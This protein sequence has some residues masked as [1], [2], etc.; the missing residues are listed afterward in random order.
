MK[1]LLLMIFVSGQALASDADCL[2]EILYAE[3]RG[4]AFE[5]VV[6]LGQASIKKADM[7]KSTLCALKGVH[8]KSPDKD[9]L[10]YYRAISKHLLSN[11]S[12]SMSRGADHWDSK[13]KPHLPGKVTRKIG[14]HIFYILTTKRPH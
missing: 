11:K 1:I 4:Q 12:T 10:E 9:M 3:A 14:G 13:A 6:T 5:G 7:E 8:K 2:A